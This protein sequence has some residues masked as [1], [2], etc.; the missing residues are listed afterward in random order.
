MEDDKQYRQASVRL[1]E[2]MVRALDILAKVECRSRC[3]VIEHALW[4]FLMSHHRHMESLRSSGVFV[5]CVNWLEC[6]RVQPAIRANR[7]AAQL[8][9]E[10]GCDD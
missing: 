10:M 5:E 7:I 3:S 2:P 9:A 6:H 8:R 1:P 4:S